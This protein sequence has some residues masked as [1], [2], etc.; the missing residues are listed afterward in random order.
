MALKGSIS[1]GVSLSTINWR[2]LFILGEKPGAPISWD[3]LPARFQHEL[4][5]WESLA[6]NPER[7]GGEAAFSLQPPAINRRAWQTPM[8]DFARGF[9]GERLWFTWELEAIK[10]ISKSSSV[11]PAFPEFLKTRRIPPPSPTFLLQP[12]QQLYQRLILRIALFSV[13]NAKCLEWLKTS[14]NHVLFPM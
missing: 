12:F 10:I 2:S 7:R 5:P 1:W 14:D 3:P 6:G 8:E 11:F 4:C 13:P 9:L